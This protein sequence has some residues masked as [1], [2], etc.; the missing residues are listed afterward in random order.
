MKPW[1]SI[2]AGGFL[3]NLLGM[4]WYGPLFMNQWLAALGTSAEEIG[5]PD[6]TYMI[7]PLAGWLVTAAVMNALYNLLARRDWSFVLRATLYA[8]VA[9]GLLANIFVN[10]F[11]KRRGFDLVWIDA[12]YILA[13][14]LIIAVCAM[15]AGRKTDE[16]S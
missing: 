4:L 6:I 7:V 11:D 15:I 13:G 16:S 5:E 2:I 14:L 8:W 10:F 3:A 9:G 1:I 12:G